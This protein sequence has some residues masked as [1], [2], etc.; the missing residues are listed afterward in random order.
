M[1]TTTTSQL[2]IARQYL[3]YQQ[4]RKIDDLLALMSDDVEL[5]MPMAGA[6]SGKAAVEK[7]LRSRPSG[8][9]NTT[10][11]EPEEEGDGVVVMGTAPFGQ[12]RV[13]F[14]FD[15][16]EERRVGKECRL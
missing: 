4:L 1:A 7:Q 16:S 11:A 9:G 10:W 5:T 14:A 8:G 15:R 2:D 13:Q 3:K 12:L 6:L